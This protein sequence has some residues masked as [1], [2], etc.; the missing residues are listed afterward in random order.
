MFYVVPN[1]T[2]KEA[3]VLWNS[4]EFFSQPPAPVE[5]VAKV[6]LKTPFHFQAE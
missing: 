6:T 3:N 5:S 1:L 2:T 4:L